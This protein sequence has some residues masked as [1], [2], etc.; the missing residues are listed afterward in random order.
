MKESLEIKIADKIIEEFK[1]EIMNILWDGK[2]NLAFDEHYLLPF[3]QEELEYKILK[4]NIPQEYKKQ[5]LIQ[6]GNI[7]G[8][9]GEDYL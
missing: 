9:Y 2:T 6:V 7:I 1:D 8:E 3:I 5:Y 4:L